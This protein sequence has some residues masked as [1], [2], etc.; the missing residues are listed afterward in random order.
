MVSI[1]FSSQIADISSGKDASLETTKQVAQELEE[2]LNGNMTNSS[3]S[4]N[5]MLPGNLDAALEA[6]AQI[7]MVHHQ[8]F[9]EPPSW[10][11]V[12]VTIV[13]D[14]VLRT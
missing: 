10:D 7:S 14:L 13:Y 11:E 6:I 12:M 2:A 9:E 1:F 8:M 4:G 3:S 5:G